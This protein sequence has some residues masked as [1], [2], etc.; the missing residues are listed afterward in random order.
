MCQPPSHK[1]KVPEHPPAAAAVAEA[2]VPGLFWDGEDGMVADSW[3]CGDDNTDDDKAPEETQRSRACGCR[4][5]QL[6]SGPGRS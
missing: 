3:D 4:A 6:V 2:E 1:V 5:N